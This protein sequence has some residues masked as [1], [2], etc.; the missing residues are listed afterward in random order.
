M[1]VVVHQVFCLSPLVFIT[2]V[3]EAFCQE[4]RT[5]WPLENLY[6]DD[7]VIITESLRDM[8]QKLILWQTNMETNGLRV[9]MDKTKVLISRLGLDVLQ[10]SVKDQCGVC[11]KG[12]GTNYIFCSF[13]SFESTRNAV[14]S[15][16]GWSLMPASGVNGALD[17]PCQ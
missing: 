8:Q 6:A 9:N 12:V 14:V 11:L 15:L 13:V 3:L 1:K 2:T 4:F 7:L 10:K 17:R 5:G 16:S